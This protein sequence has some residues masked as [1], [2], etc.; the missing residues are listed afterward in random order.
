TNSIDAGT[1]LIDNTTYYVT[2]TFEACE[3][4]ALTVTAHEVSC[5]VLEV[6][7]T[8][9]SS[10]CGEGSVTLKAGGAEGTVGT[11][12]HWYD[13]AVDG[14]LVER[15][16]E[17]ITPELEETTSYW[18]AEVAASDEGSTVTGQGLVSPSGGAVSQN[19][20][21]NGILFDAKIDFIIE[22]VDVYVAQGGGNLEITIFDDADN[23]RSE[24]RRVV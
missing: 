3:S 24:D 13:A 16:N 17:F 5:S 19:T 20:S 15:G 21:G 14:S 22:S 2:Q 8:S 9:P 10:V 7:S 23:V 11:E 4:G 12:L 6:T 18:V 1:L